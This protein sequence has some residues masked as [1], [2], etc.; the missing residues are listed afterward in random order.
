MSLSMGFL[1]AATF[2]LA[3]AVLCL[4]RAVYLL[5]KMR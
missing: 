5:A 3:V 2:F 1:Y 4:A